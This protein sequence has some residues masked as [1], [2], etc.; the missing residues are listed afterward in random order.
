MHGDP[1]PVASWFMPQ[2]ARSGVL[3]ERAQAL[4][5]CKRE[6]GETWGVHGSH[7]GVHEGLAKGET[8]PK[9]E[10]G[11]PFKGVLDWDHLR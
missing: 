5:A 10:Y 7:L 4:R 9:I 3:D 1:K 8:V 6:W 2:A 11:H